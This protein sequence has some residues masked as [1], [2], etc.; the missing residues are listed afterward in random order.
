MTR[1]LAN[2]RFW[3]LTAVL[4]W[5]GGITLLIAAQP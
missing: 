3:I 2:L 4:A 1:L 5:I